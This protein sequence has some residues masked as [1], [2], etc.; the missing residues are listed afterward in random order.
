MEINNQKIFTQ[1][2]AGVFG[3]TI[4]GITGFLTMIDYGGNHGCWS[5]VES[6]FNLIGYE[7]CGAFG[8]II[9]ETMGVILGITI[10]SKMKISNYLKVAKLLLIGAFLLPFLYGVI[11]F[12]PP[13]ENSNLIIVPPIILT[14]MFL[15]VVPSLLITV[16]INWRKFTLIKSNKLL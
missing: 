8:Q 15:A 10:F 12:W 2:T 16:I 4:L 11:I 5:F 7:A 14:H 3:G 1:F 9:G 6:F 13:F